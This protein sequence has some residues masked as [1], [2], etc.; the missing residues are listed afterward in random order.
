LEDLEVDGKLTFKR[1]FERRRMMTLNEFICF[2][3]ESNGRHSQ[4]R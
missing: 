3:I 2:R 1:I 4:Q